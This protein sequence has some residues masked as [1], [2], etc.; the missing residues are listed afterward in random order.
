M[1]ND[2]TIYDE[3]G[4]QV[5]SL[6]RLCS[7]NFFDIW[8]KF[9]FNRDQ[10]HG[11]SSKM[12]FEYIN[13]LILKMILSGVKMLSAEDVEIQVKYN[14]NFMWGNDG[15]N[16]LSQNVR[17]SIVLYQFTV[18]RSV[19]E[20]DINGWW[21]GDQTSYSGPYQFSDGT[22]EQGYENKKKFFGEKGVQD[23]LDED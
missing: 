13:Q 1:G 6:Y 22:I 4:N 9:G 3:D 14:A 7:G 16:R 10:I 12:V 5:N 8:Q 18:Y 19:A 23:N 21:F 2:W 11:H 17:E 15:K 20:F